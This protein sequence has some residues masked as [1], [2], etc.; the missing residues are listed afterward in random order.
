VYF[1]LNEVLISELT[2]M[3]WNSKKKLKGT[4]LVVYEVYKIFHSVIIH[5]FK[6]GAFIFLE[7]FCLRRKSTDKQTPSTKSVSIC[8]ECVYCY[9]RKW[10]VHASD[11][12]VRVATVSFL[13]SVIF[14]STHG[15]AKERSSGLSLTP[16]LHILWLA[17]SYAAA[18]FVQTTVIYRN[19][20]LVQVQMFPQFLSVITRLTL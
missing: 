9:G 19:M 20:L 13:M 1:K 8:V 14:T 18:S 17:T 3:R 5:K 15:T 4:S 2:D 7:C 6:V 16:C 11:K 10:T 12:F